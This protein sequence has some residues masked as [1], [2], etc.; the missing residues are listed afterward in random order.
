MKKTTTTK[1]DALVRKLHVPNEEIGFRSALL[2]LEVV[3][4]RDQERRGDLDAILEGAHRVAAHA[5][6]IIQTI[7]TG[8][9]DEPP[10]ENN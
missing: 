3:H 10:Q 2:R 7:T 6:L 4:L 9:K 8:E 5:L 1:L